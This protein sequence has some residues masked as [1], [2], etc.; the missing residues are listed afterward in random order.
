MLFRS[1][2]HDRTVQNMEQEQLRMEWEK[3]QA[4]NQSNVQWNGT[5]AFSS[6]GNA[7]LANEY[8]NVLSLNGIMG[9]IDIPTIGVYLPIQHE[10]PKVY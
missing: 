10:H 6:P 9:Y 8:L 3:A 2:Q 1:L 5:G 4:Y 7:P